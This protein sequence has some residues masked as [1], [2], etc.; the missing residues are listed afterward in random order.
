MVN[1]LRKEIVKAE[2]RQ[3]LLI[4]HL[5]GELYQSNE[6]LVVVCGLCSLSF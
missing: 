5:L 6:L 3:E 1:L 4:A 2:Y